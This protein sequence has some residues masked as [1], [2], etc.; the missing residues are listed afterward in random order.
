MKS[1]EYCI[2]EVLPPP[3]VPPPHPPIF[4]ISLTGSIIHALRFKR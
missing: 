2:L 1:F 3:T 4:L